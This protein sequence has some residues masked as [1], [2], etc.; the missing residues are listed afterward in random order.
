MFFHLIQNIALLLSLFIL[1][2][3]CSKKKPDQ[4]LVEQKCRAHISE[5]VKRKPLR[6][7]EERFFKDGKS[8]DQIKLSQ[9][10]AGDF[11]EG[12][13]SATISTFIHEFS[14][15]D[16]VG[17]LLR[18]HRDPTNG[19]VSLDSPNLVTPRLQCRLTWSLFKKKV[20]KIELKVFYVNLETQSDHLRGLVD[21]L[22]SSF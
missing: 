21:T 20:M 18:L 15:T 17:N 5:V 12:N 16:E 1:H 9:M 13:S 22:E 6:R 19:G 10:R 4:V 7:I 11:G 8:R 3:G 2:S 14:F